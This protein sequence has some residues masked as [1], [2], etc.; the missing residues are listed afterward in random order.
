MSHHIKKMILQFV[1]LSEKM[2][3]NKN[4]DVMNNLIIM[5]CLVCFLIVLFA[6]LPAERA[7][8][9]AKCFKLV[10]SAFSISKICDAI[11]SYYRNKNEQ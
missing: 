11:I 4:I 2:N 1:N 8:R 3:S 7:Y 10:A 9:A 6:C 5:S